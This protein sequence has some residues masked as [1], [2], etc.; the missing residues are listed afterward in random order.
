M[1]TYVN[2]IKFTDQG[3]KNAK[4]TVQRLLHF[5]VTLSVEAV[6]C[7][8]STGL[9][10]STTLLPPFRLLTSRRQ[11]PLRLPS[12]AWAMCAQKP[13]VRSMRARCSPLFRKSDPC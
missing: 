8:A 1:P 4:D 13:C 11:W 10:D 5:V 3:I 12:R 6:S 7:S 9:K 2:L